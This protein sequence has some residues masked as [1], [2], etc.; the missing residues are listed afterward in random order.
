MH[1]HMAAETL[2]QNKR[3]RAARLSFRVPVSCVSAQNLRHPKCPWVPRVAGRRTRW[4][5][6]G[7]SEQLIFCIRI[8]N[9]FELLLASCL[10]INLGG[11][12]RPCS[13]REKGAS[14]SEIRTRI[15]IVETTARE[16]LLLPQKGR[17][18]TRRGDHCVNVQKNAG[19]CLVLAG[20]PTWLLR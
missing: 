3:L 19:F 11:T 5:V 17:P 12:V 18:R 10:M 4:V 7:A 9:Q 2:T 20:N 8:S 6:P 15:S 16:G 1:A 13:D 14:R